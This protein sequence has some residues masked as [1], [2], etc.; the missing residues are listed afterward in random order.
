[1]IMDI[2][3]MAI[4]LCKDNSSEGCVLYC[5]AK[6]DLLEDANNYAQQD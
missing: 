4:I 2:P 1:M 3:D 5:I 6:S